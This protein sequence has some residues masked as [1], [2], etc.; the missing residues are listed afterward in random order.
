MKSRIFSLSLFCAVFIGLSLIPA[1]L[2]YLP[3]FTSE[4]G[5]S[6]LSDTIV[7]P[8]DDVLNYTVSQ[9]P[10]DATVGDYHDEVDILNV[11]VVSYTKAS[12]M[13]L[14]IW[15]AAAPGADYMDYT[16]TIYI[17][18]NSDGVGD[19]WIYSTY[20][21]LSEHKFSVINFV[22]YRV[23]DGK[24]YDPAS[25]WVASAVD[26][27]WA[28]DGDMLH[29]HY[30]DEIIP[31]IESSRIAMNVVYIGQTDIFY[32]DFVPFKLPGVPG[33]PLGLV[34]F[35]LLTLLGFAMLLQKNQIRF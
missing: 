13:D 23:S 1:T 15:F 24:Y 7:D 32:A 5:W 25:G 21:P 17:D 34:L 6:S 30:M 12:L 3:S 31:E 8:P 11:S 28:I 19:Y 16:Y 26:T 33:F 18:N 14:V 27:S 10:T 4:Y 29:F 2:A 9:L 35:G 22:I 20:I